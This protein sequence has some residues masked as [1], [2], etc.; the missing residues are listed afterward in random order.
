MTTVKVTAEEARDVVV[1]GGVLIP[2][3]REVGRQDARIP[4]LRQRVE[5]DGQ[6]DAEHDEDVDR[7]G[8]EEEHAGKP[9]FAAHLAHPFPTIEA[10][11]YILLLQARTKEM[12]DELDRRHDHRDGGGGVE[13]EFLEG[14]LVGRYRDDSRRTRGLAEEDGRGE[15]REGHHEIEAEGDRDA[16]DHQG[17]EDLPEGLPLVGAEHLAG[18]LEIGIDARYVAEEH[19]ESVGE[20]LEPERDHDAEELCVNLKGSF[21]MRRAMRSWLS[22]PAGPMKV[23][24]PSDIKTVPRVMGTMRK[25]VISFSPRIPRRM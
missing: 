20:A 8:D 5:D 25:K 23:S 16:G 24:M 14:P 12:T 15:D 6:E 1:G 10:P 2:F 22:Q 21:T 17:E 7:D 3:R 11:L 19:E 13:V 4:A 18:L 9:G